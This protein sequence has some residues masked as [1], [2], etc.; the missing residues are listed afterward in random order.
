MPQYQNMNLN[1]RGM[2]YSLFPRR[3]IKSL[4]LL[5]LLIIIVP[6]NHI[7]SQARQEIKMMFY[8][9]ESWILFEDFEE[10]LIKNLETDSR[11]ID[12]IKINDSHYCL[13]LAD[14]GMNARIVKRFE[15]EGSRGMAG[16]GKQ[17]FRE[18][19]EGKT[20][21]SFYIEMPGLRRRKMKAE[22]VVIA[23]AKAFGTGAVINPTG[24]M[25]DG[26]FEVIVIRP[27]PWWFVLI[28]IWAVFSG[29]L[30]RMKYVRI[31]SAS[32]ARITLTENQAFQVD[33]EVLEDADAIKI[34]IIPDAL[35]MIGI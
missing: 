10:A 33:G 29:T 7:Y 17:L 18:L 23:N 9:A 24:R 25:N 30:H 19:F 21:F 35:H 3:I 32:E 12:V 27:Y 26:K 13:H 22:M 4:T 28:F 31:F 14:I 16:Y 20:F 2:S 6:G 5:L 34:K 15:K 11:P 8:E 1:R